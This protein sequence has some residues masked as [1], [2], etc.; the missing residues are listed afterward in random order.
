MMK[1]KVEKMRRRRMKMGKIKRMKKMRKRT[2]SL[3]NWQQTKH[4]V[5]H[6]LSSTLLPLSSHSLD[7]DKF[8]Q[9]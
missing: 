9:K 1:V 6:Y 7:L 3:L 8:Q 2:G 5:V 4:G